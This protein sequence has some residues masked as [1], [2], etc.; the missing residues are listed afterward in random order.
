MDN[1]KKPKKTS[2][3]DLGRFISLILRHKPETI[4]ITLDKNG[5]ADTEQL[6]HGINMSGHYIDMEILERI[7]RENNKKTWKASNSYS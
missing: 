5:W 1:I 6:L 3:I 4:H 7:V 2:D